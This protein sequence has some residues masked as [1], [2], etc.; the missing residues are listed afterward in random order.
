MILYLDFDGVLHHYDVYLDRRNRPIL[1]GMGKLFEYAEILESALDP[2]P[3]V[4]I[5]L[6]TSWVRT[7][8]FSYARKRLPP[9]LRER[10][11]GATW[12]STFR[13]DPDLEFWWVKYSSRYQQVSR[14]LARRQP[15]AWLALDDDSEGWPIEANGNLVLCDPLLAF[16]DEHVQAALQKAL[17][18]KGKDPA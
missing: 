8:G 6:S 2:Y 10:V 18:R 9:G 16:G 11:I 3:E 7:K 4:E 14:D 12:H 13:R 1:R 15:Q 5:V 17:Q